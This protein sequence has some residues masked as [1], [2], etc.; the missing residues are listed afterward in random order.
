MGFQHLPKKKVLAI[1]QKGGA[2]GGHRFTSDEARDA[3]K[4][5]RRG[6]DKKPRK[7]K[8]DR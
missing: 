2:A 7:T 1:A 8:G 4:K 6:P 5:S 3:G